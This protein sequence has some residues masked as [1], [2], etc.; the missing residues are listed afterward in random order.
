MSLKVR[1]A[2]SA[3][4]VFLVASV[5]SMLGQ[6][7]QGGVR[8]LV[9]DAQG[10]IIPK[11]QVSLI[12]QATKITRVSETNGDGQYVFTAVEPATYT[13]SIIASGFASTER[14]FVTVGPQ[15]F[16][17]VDFKLSVGS[18]AQRVEVRASTPPVDQAD[19]SNSETIDTRK[20]EDLPVPSR[21]PYLTAKLESN[22]IETGT[23]S[24][25]VRFADQTGLSYV[26]IAG[27]PLASNNYLIDGVPI[28]DLN[29][30]PV[31]V[32]SIEAVAELTVQQNS[33]DAEVGRTGGGTFTTFLKSG[34]DVLHGTLYGQTRQ[35]D[36][37][38]KPYFYTPGSPLNTDF[39][40]YAGAVGGPVV[41]PHVYDGRH[42]TFFWFTEEGYRQRVPVTGKFYVPTALERAGDFSQSSQKI[43]N[44]FAPL[45]PCPAPSTQK[46]RQQFP[47]NVI[48]SNLIDPVGQAIVNNL[49]LP[50][51]AVTK[52][53]ATD[54]SNTVVELKRA[55]DFSG[56][57]DDQLFS[58]WSANVS[59]MHFGSDDPS[60]S[61]LQVLP[62]GTALLRKVDAVSEHNTLTISPTTLLTIGYGFNRFPNRSISFTEGFNQTALGFPAG[63]V[64]ALQADRFPQISMQTTASLGANPGSGVSGNSV[65]YSRSLVVGLAKSLGRQS[66]TL[67]Y[68]F[69]SLS[70]DFLDASFG[71]GLYSFT[72]IFSEQL[73]NAGTTAG[74]A[75]VADLLL[76]TPASGQVTTTSPLRLNVRYHGIYVQDG[77]RLTPRLTFTAGLRYEYELGVRERSDQL[78]VGFNRSTVNPLSAISGVTTLGG[79][80]YAGINGYP[81]HCC[82]NSH[83]KLAPRVGIAYSPRDD[84]SVRAGYGVFYPP[85]FYTNSSL[86]APGYT[87][88]N[89]YVASND[90]NVTPTH[91][92]SNPFPSGLQP[93]SGNSQGYL[94]GIGN[95]LT[96]LDQYRRSP[97]V[98]QYSMDI[99][100]AFPGRIVMQIGYT[101]SKGR[102]LQ[103][104]TIGL[105]TYNIN[106][107]PDQDL[108]LGSQLA[109]KVPNP[110]FNHGGSGVVGSSTVAYNQLLRPFPEFSNVNIASSTAK[111]LYNALNLRFEKQMSQGISV[112]ATYTWSSNWDS[113]WGSTSSINSGPSAPQDAYNLK[114][115]YAR[116]IDDIPNRFSVG[117]IVELPLGYGK[118]FLGGSGLLNRFIGGWSVNAIVFLQNGAPLA[119]SQSSNNNSSIGAGVQRPNLVG[120]PCYSGGPESRI[121]NYLNAA[122]FSTAPAYTYGNSPRTLPCYGPG[123]N[124][125]DLSV[126]KN[127]QFERFNFQFRAEALNAFNTPQFT[128][129]VVTFGS[130]T[131]GQILNTV[132]LPRY[133]QL[134][135]K[136]FF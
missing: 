38:A 64:N 127:F 128:A 45:I 55:D 71:N 115:E 37:T 68:D 80:E 114:A 84:T 53:G 14:R 34:T 10:A 62:A 44:P 17:T 126:F 110:Y 93:P 42:K 47:N 130:P 30:R 18:V 112:L 25:S 133:V 87:Q 116:A 122:A 120:N 105:G 35:T 1:F 28:T 8:G 27:S 66:V 111:S 77:M 113:A 4:G 129:P 20:I 135:G 63:Y 29:N 16:L 31:I 41:I 39:Y 69:R 134:G 33:Y 32:P 96:V 86:L 7:Y 57:V 51:Q 108:S 60:A 91:T 49:P 132:N 99:Q 24:G 95:S 123:L 67:G 94:T 21:N 74:G 92:L 125:L 73:P 22:V 72:N 15:Q 75:D 117:T 101:G 2:F 109:S 70:V 36:W 76:G 97:I 103:P 40:D 136:V 90:G 43:Y 81:V 48:P 118:R 82:N 102:N 107:L 89:T 12:D 100:K 65:F 50:N 79:V 54:F 88:T 58:W 124:N 85:L 46:C 119:V 106:Q 6:S 98:Q 19:A 26:S 78:A 13:V 59:Y 52:Y 11:A 9:T 61:A 83:L 5:V 23:P 3:S 131:F 56:K 121:N 104:S